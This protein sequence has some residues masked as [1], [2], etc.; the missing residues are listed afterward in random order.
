MATTATTIALTA[1]IFAPGG[2]LGDPLGKPWGAFGTP[3]RPLQDPLGT[4]RDHQA[5]PGDPMAGPRTAL[6]PSKRA[7]RVAQERWSPPREPPE[8]PKSRQERY[9]RSNKRQNTSPRGPKGAPRGSLKSPRLTK[10]PF[11]IMASVESHNAYILELA[12]TKFLL[13]CNMAS[14]G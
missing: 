7:P 13:I 11:H 10:I 9:K 2:P 4:P 12:K 1:Y 6:E 3:W 5:P 14:N 8:W